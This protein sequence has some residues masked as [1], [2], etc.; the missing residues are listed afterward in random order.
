[1]GK[2]DTPLSVE[3]LLQ[4]QDFRL[5]AVD[6]AMNLFELLA[7][8]QNGMTLSELSRKLNMPKSSAHYLIYTLVSRGY[9]QR[10]GDGRHYMLGL[11]LADVVSAS[12][13]E[14]HLRTL[15]M[16]CLRQL[17]ARIKLTATVTVLHGAEAVIIAKVD[18]F[19]DAGGGAWIGRH[20]DLHCTAQGKALI[21]GMSESELDKLFAGR[22]LARFTPR[23]ISSLRT[24]KAH[25]AQVRTIGY[26]TND[27]EQVAGVRAVAAPI[28]DPA[29][30]V[31][32]AVSVRGST[33]QLSV[34]AFPQMGRDMIAASHEISQQLSCG[35]F[36]CA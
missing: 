10:G 11:R 6:R 14:L 1:M 22:E 32:A 7:R 17:G 31:I 19:Q 18:S 8:S 3:A 13:A 12:P 20:I 21:S 28:I 15:A 25:L 36:P 24:L 2:L 5:P 9:V 30:T 29:G 16:P 33:Q 27:E 34:A 23:T 26:A 4:G 35:Y